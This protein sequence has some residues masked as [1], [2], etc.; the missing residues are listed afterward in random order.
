MADPNSENLSAVSRI[1]GDDT[2]RVVVPNFITEIV[3]RDLSSGDVAQVLTRF[4]PEPNGYLHI[5]HLK[6]IVLDFG[7]ADDFGG[8]TNLRF[9]DTNPT[10]ENEEYVEVI[11]R[12]IRWLG[13]EWDALVHAS[14][15]FEQLYRFAQGLIRDGRAYVDSL[16]EAE[17]REYRG[18]VTKAG[19]ESP[20]R[21]RQVTENLDLFERMRQGEFAEGAHVLRAKI[22]MSSRNMMMRDPLLYRIRH[23]HHYRTGNEWHIYP[24]YDF[25]HPLS[26][27]IEGVSHSLCTLEF[28]NNRELYDWLLEKTVAPPRPHQYEF[29][30]LNLEYTV[31]SK[32][33]LIELV[34]GGLVNGWDDPRMPTVA[35]LRRRGVT[36]E[37]LLEFVNKVGVT[38]TESRSDMALL[39]H[40]IRDDLNSKAP[41]VMAVLE[42]LRVVISSY[43]E[44]EGETIDAPYWPHDVP[45]EGSRPLP[46]GRELF[47]ERG[48]FAEDPPKGWR[49]LSP[50][51]QV[52]L[53]HSYVIRCDEVVKDS[54]GKVVELICSHDP[55]T[56]GRNPTAGRVKGTIHW[57]S[58]KEA[59]PAEFRLYDRLFSS[60]DPNEGEGPF[61][62]RLNPESLKVKRGL[63]EPS[64]AG[65]QSGKRYQFER[66]GYF[67][68]DPVD[69]SSNALV[70]NRI[71][72][73]KDSWAKVEASLPPPSVKAT[74]KH[75]APD[76][77]A[78]TRSSGVGDPVSELSVE[79]K[80]IYTQYRDLLGLDERDA[81]LLAASGELAR[82]FEEAARRHDNP[83]GIAGWM[84]NELLRELKGRDL[85]EL[86][87]T[88]ESFADLVALVDSQAIS[89]RAAKE[90]FA[91][92]LA[93]GGDPGKIV[94]ELGLRQM[95]DEGVLLPLVERLL[96]QHPDKVRAY[97]GGKTGL[98]GF[99]V[100]RV[101]QET[102]GSAKPQLVK[103]V[104]ERELARAGG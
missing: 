96:K 75:T 27:A 45:N 3:E 11:K 78:P 61:T 44:A 99:F 42:P 53:R 52:R 81:L 29:A 32:R 40:S 22:D 21:E 9:D 89:A 37:A 97:Q 23:A 48:D 17:I 49:R 51:A 56:Q 8:L 31:L 30:R 13:F 28:E 43:P 70:F 5:G 26:D 62:E 36:P 76:N 82:F 104:V 95:S 1:P 102:G 77:E 24:M 10:T 92:M 87:V 66:L 57:L 84:V 20:N 59:L 55:E 19:R 18:T 68:P 71:V 93:N 7:I 41:R 79:Q 2:K 88:P 83:K 73:L 4:P 33:R 74:G 94:D 103:E 35:G 50:G 63:V 46:M 15:Y 47:I 67:W 91:Q 80:T 100:G 86:S 25:A 69:S 34:R 98:A 39:E 14:D 12:D 54:S 60:A 85:A 58:S 6:A 16:S 65:D 64:L 90:V 72:T 38:R 101:M